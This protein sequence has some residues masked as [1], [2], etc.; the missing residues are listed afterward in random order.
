MH[1]FGFHQA[2]DMLMTSCTCIL[3]CESCTQTQQADII[4]TADL[5]PFLTV[6][7]R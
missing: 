3:W 6:A 2:T 5:V 4:G 7:R 1:M